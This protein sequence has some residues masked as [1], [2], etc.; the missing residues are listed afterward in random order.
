M[1]F[2]LM[3]L[4]LGIGWVFAPSYAIVAATISMHE[5]KP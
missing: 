5:T 3:H 4:A 1:V 2:F